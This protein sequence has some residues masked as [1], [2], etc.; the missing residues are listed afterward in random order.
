MAYESH[1]KKN[2]NY[3]I[4]RKYETDY[5]NLLNSNNPHPEIV[6]RYLTKRNKALDK[7]RQSANES[8]KANRRVKTSYTNTVNSLLSNPS[9]TAKKEI[10]YPSETDEKQ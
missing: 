1:T 4:Y 9:I 8:C 5:K 2:R 3:Q 6:T 10:W 7:S